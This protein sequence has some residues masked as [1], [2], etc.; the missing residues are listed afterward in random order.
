[1]DLFGNLT[2]LINDLEGELTS[3]ITFYGDTVYIVLFIVICA[4]TLFVFTPFLPGE[5]LLFAVGIIASR[6]SLNA[7][8]LFILL[9]AAAI[10]GDSANFGIG[11]F[12]GSI[13]FKKNFRFLK[14][15]YLIKAQHFYEKHG[16]KT[17][18]IARFIPVTRTFAPFIAGLGAMTYSRFLLFNILGGILWCATFVY[19][20]Y[21]F[22][23]IKFIREN[24]SL[25]IIII[26]LIFLFAIVIKLF[27]NSL[28]KA[29]LQA[30]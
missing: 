8:T 4:E 13:I 26:V 18:V 15:A 19:G 23:S 25:I 22:G 29:K 14:K 27:K 1:M 16:G 10:I 9:S 11:N 28:K 6:G 20:G 5:S 30:E 24:F 2:N 17:I 12:M 21:Y 3:I 7:N